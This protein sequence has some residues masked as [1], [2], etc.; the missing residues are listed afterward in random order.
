MGL[1]GNLRDFALKK[2]LHTVGLSG[3]TGILT[4]KD[5]ETGWEI[6]FCHG[7]VV[8]AGIESPNDDPGAW[9]IR[10]EVADRNRLDRA[11]ALLGNDPAAGAVT[12]ILRDRFGVDSAAIER[13]GRMEI[14][15]VITDLL[16][17][18]RGSFI[19]KICWPEELADRVCSPFGLLLEEGIEPHHF[20]KADSGQAPDGEK[21]QARRPVPA[22][23]P[24]P[25]AAARKVAK[26]PL[27]PQ[28]SPK[29]ASFSRVE[30]TISIRGQVFLLDDDPLVRE[31]LGCGLT[32]LGWD[33]AVFSRSG[34]LLAELDRAVDQGKRPTLLI[35]LVMPRL[36]GDGILGGL[37]LLQVIRSRYPSLPI[38]M[39]SDFFC[40][41]T[42]KKI[43][44]LGVDQLV[45]KPHRRSLE[46]E[47]DSSLPAFVERI[48]KA[49]PSLGGFSG[50]AQ[51][52]HC[53]EERA[54]SDF[55]WPA[56]PLEEDQDP[57]KRQL[58]LLKTLSR[59][60][61]G[62]DLG[63]QA[64]LLL[65]RFAAELFDRAII[66]SVSSNRM[67]GSGQFGFECFSGVKGGRLCE[68]N[69]SL[70]E[71]SIFSAVVKDLMPVKIRLGT[72][73]WKR[74]FAGWL[75]APA[76]EEVFLGP[77]VCQGGVVGILYGDILPGREPV[78]ET[79]GLEV[80]LIQMGL[81]KDKARL[82]AALA[83]QEEALH[84]SGSIAVAK[85]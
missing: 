8:W 49:L 68:L 51:E 50:V 71:P 14:E 38:L 32:E 79:A 47:E 21:S 18:Q 26:F 48:A 41:E 58:A 3:Q 31:K 82:E 20:L 43:Q 74:S 54:V 75:D 23:G 85:R 6:V 77:I 28:P 57:V 27:K 65:L 45:V 46:M 1:I 52:I 62:P 83:G 70:R 24:K 69:I 7:K 73:D 39:F 12:A 59:E 10:R 81:V 80:F 13:A 11:L 40:T 4:L 84:G 35:D 22:T 2:I 67:H 5:G 34:D 17:W 29:G 61:I 9:L 37:E 64:R 66:F 42:E 60:L 63:E 36:N 72:E 44:N 76:A 25:P 78:G 16:G 19:F 55:F 53:E 15:S 33:V 30:P 56:A